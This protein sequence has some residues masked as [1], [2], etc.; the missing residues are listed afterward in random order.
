MRVAKRVNY[1]EQDFSLLQQV[2]RWRWR[3]CSTLP[4]G[5]IYIW[6]FLPTTQLIHLVFQQQQQQ[7]KQQNFD[8]HDQQHSA[9]TW[10]QQRQLS[11]TR[12]SYI[13]GFAPTL[14]DRNLT[15]W[16]FHFF[17]VCCCAYA[18]DHTK[19]RTD[20]AQGTTAFNTHRPL[21]VQPTAAGGV[22]ID[23]K[24]DI[25]EGKAGFTD[26][27]IGKVQKV[28]FFCLSTQFCCIKL[29]VPSVAHT[30]VTG[31]YTNNPELH[32]KGELRESGGKAAVEGEARAPHD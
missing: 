17:G 23:G 2:W 29:I 18:E 5:Y 4:H 9:P 11:A 28:R 1:S 32:E 15:C 21:N 7:Q 24:D 12:A 22:A 20:S 27:V 16:H 8:N 26:K 6:T 25:P 14:H 3:H 19:Q 30:Q 13:S 31:K 10:V